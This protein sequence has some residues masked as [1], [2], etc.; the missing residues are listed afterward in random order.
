MLALGHYIFAC[1]DLDAFYQIPLP[2]DE[3]G[4]DIIQNTDF[5]STYGIANNTT[6]HDPLMFL[7]LKRTNS[8]SWESTPLCFSF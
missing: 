1:E 4:I 8:V 6:E 3:S 5:A 2:L 7:W